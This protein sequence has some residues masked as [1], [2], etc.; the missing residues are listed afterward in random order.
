MF[1]WLVNTRRKCRA[2]GR[3]QLS[4]LNE[5]KW[6]PKAKTIAPQPTWLCHLFHMSDRSSFPATGPLLLGGIL[7]KN[8]NLIWTCIGISL[9]SFPQESFSAFSSFTSSSSFSS[10]ASASDRRVQNCTWISSSRVLNSAGC[11][12][13]ELA[14]TCRKSLISALTWM[15]FLPS[16]GL[17]VTPPRLW[18]WFHGQLHHPDEVVAFQSESVTSMLSFGT[19]LYVTTQAQYE[20]V[21]EWCP[22]TGFWS[23][24]WILICD[25]SLSKYGKALEGNNQVSKSCCAAFAIASLCIFSQLDKVE[26]GTWNALQWLNELTFQYVNTCVRL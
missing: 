2:S 3:T 7:R 23:K 6:T 14:L 18:W 4:E 5:L 22:S 20:N 12:V 10:L 1:T 16:H 19:A 15:P 24:C 25:S 13:T 17:W 21:L 8:M 11:Y 9:Y 26:V